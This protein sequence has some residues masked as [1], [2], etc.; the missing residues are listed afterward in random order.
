[1]NL[2]MVAQLITAL[3]FAVQQHIYGSSIRRIR[4][5][6]QPAQFKGEEV[7]HQ[8]LV[9][10]IVDERPFLGIGGSVEHVLRAFEF[11]APG[12]LGE[13]SRSIAAFADGTCLG[14]KSRGAI[15]DDR[16]PCFDF[17]YLIIGNNS[18]GCMNTD[19]REIGDTVQ[20]RMVA[21]TLMSKELEFGNMAK[22]A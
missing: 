13:V 20:V 14:E 10:I 12:L 3:V 17:V 18:I 22:A 7:A 19:C 8:G 21:H 2:N 1:M 16:E 15:P 5:T 6:H 11:D 9:A 4:H